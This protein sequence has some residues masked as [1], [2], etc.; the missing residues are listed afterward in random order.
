MPSGGP[1]GAP[2]A[3]PPW[4]PLHLDRLRE[5][6][7]EALRQFALVRQ[8]TSLAGAN[9]EGGDVGGSGSRRSL[10]RHV[11][12]YLAAAELAER[13]G[14]GGP[15]VDV[16]GGVGALARW[17]A[18]RLDLPLHLVDTDPGVRAVAGAVFPDVVV[19]SRLEELPPGS[20][21]LVTAM[22]VVEHLPHRDQLAFLKGLSELLRPGGLLVLSTPDESSYVGGWSGYAP[23]VGVLDVDQLRCL[24]EEAGLAATIWRLQGDVFHVGNAKRVLQ[25]AVNRLWAAVGTLA[26]AVVDRATHRAGLILTRLRGWRREDVA[27]DLDVQ[28]RAVAPE[29]GRGGGLLAAAQIPPAEVTHAAKR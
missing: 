23:H 22:E 10:L 17:L 7:E 18:A 26:P 8:I 4:G 29:Q 27:V 9:R 12:N 6:A 1:A 2:H 20:A 13:L 21:G 15:M 3:R 25:P 5:A 11:A 28:V 24:L 16:G 19:H 14:V